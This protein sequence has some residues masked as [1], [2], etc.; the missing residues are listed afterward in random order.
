MPQG[1][2]PFSYVVYSSKI[3]DFGIEGDDCFVIMSI[4]YNEQAARTNRWNVSTV[5]IEKNGNAARWLK[6][7]GGRC[8]LRRGFLPSSTDE[9]F[10][11]GRSLAC[12]LLIPK[13]ED[14]HASVLP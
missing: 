8:F 7:V 10:A 14:P 1:D 3:R 4:F 12:P 2:R 13:L 5:C 9:M 6:P 11:Q